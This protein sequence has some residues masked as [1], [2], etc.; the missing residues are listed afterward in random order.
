MIA[1]QKRLELEA[2]KF[3]TNLDLIFLRRLRE[4]GCQIHSLK[5]W[6][7]NLMYKHE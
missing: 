5:E 6:E 7:I 3:E 1:K 2:K 4:E